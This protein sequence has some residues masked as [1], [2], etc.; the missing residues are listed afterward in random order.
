MNKTILELLSEVEDFRIGNAIKHNLT[1]ILMIGLLTIICNGNTFADMF[2]FGKTHEK[3][4][5]EFLELPHGIPSQDTFEHVFAKL[6][7]VKLSKHFGIWVETLV[8]QLEGAVIAIDGKTIRRS[9]SASKKATHVVTAFAT[10]MQ[11]V[12]GQI[13]TEEKSN[14]ITAIPQL[15]ELFCAK[16]KIITIDAMGTQTAIAEKIIEKEADYILSLKGN[17]PTLFEDVKLYLDCE[18]VTKD[19][20]DLNLRNLYA[21]TVEKAH[22]RIESRECFICSD[23]ERLR[24]AENWAELNGIGVIISKREEIGKERTEN[25]EYFIYSLKNAAATDILRIKRSHWSIENNLH[26]ALDVTFREDD[27]RARLEN[28]AENLNILRK[29]ALQLMKGE[30]SK[31]ISMRQKR[32]LCSYDLF[33][34][35]KVIG[36]K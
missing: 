14:E 25:R 29:Q 31:K 5:K 11:L 13:A 19:K 36:V 33:Y 26:P 7:P 1:D 30:T 28:A 21:K 2:L 4:L 32:L 9:K 18:V 6:N 17:Q 27:C 22:G 15:L 16:D 3:E 20:K 34:A 8:K 35:F 23:I 12:L 10:E 24:G